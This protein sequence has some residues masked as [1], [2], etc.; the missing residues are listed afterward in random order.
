MWNQHALVVMGVP[1]AP[2]AFAPGVVP[3]IR[4]P[5]RSA[6]MPNSLLGWLPTATQSQPLYPT[7]PALT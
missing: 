6:D 1:T 7:L 4:I 2:S 3:V 5:V